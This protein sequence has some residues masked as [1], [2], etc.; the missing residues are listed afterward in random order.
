MILLK[1]YL[2]CVFGAIFYILLTNITMRYIWKRY[3]RD[4]RHR[5][6][7]MYMMV[8]TW[9]Q[10][11][12][13]FKVLAVVLPV[14]NLLFD[15]LAVI[16]IFT[17]IRHGWFN[18]GRRVVHRFTTGR[19]K[20]RHFIIKDFVVR[21]FFRSWRDHFYDMYEDKLFDRIIKKVIQE[22]EKAKSIKKESE[23]EHEEHHVS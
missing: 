9:V 4:E 10:A 22:N 5:N 23:S 13:Y 6:D 3:C 8:Q 21:I 2:W 7:M 16:L 15:I 14:I 20:L 1:I 12:V 19:N 17:T 11:P 18:L